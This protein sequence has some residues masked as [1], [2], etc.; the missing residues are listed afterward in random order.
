MLVF[1]SSALSCTFAYTY[2]VGNELLY[3]QLKQLILLY[4]QDRFL[5]LGV[6][7]VPMSVSS[8]YCTVGF[9]EQAGIAHK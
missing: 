4:R 8:K 9:I 6:S 5:E 3:T 7:S 2:S 1:H